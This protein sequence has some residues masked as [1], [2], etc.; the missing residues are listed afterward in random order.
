MDEAL[1]AWLGPAFDELTGTQRE[2]VAL[3]A[4]HLSV[5]WPSPDHSD[6]RQDA[7]N[8]YV[9]ALLGEN[10]KPKVHRY[11]I[12]YAIIVNGRPGTGSISVA[13]EDHKMDEEDVSKAMA[14][15][16]KQAE[17]YDSDA[18]M[19]NVTSIWKFED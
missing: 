6:V 12:S 10:D 2:M 19:P 17:G 15:V 4:A 16:R 1:K 3:K 8:T 13:F 9:Q 18:S 11:L 7:L 5:Q 14:L